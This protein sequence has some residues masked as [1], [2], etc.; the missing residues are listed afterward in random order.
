PTSDTL[1]LEAGNATEGFDRAPHRVTFSAH[2]PYQAHATFA[3]NCALADVKAGSALVMCSSQDVYNTRRVLAPL[4]GLTEQQ[5]RVQFCDGAGTY[6]HSCYDDATQA[7]ALLSQLAGAPVRVQFMRAD[8]HGWDSYGPAHVGEVRAAADAA[9]KIVAYEYHGW[10]HHWSLVETSQ[11]LALG[12]AP[13]EW[14]N[15]VSQQV[16]PSNCGA[17]YVI[18]NKRLVDHRLKTANYLRAGWLRSP[19]DLSMAFAS[20]QAIDDLAFQLGMD[21]YEFRRRNMTDE[22]WLGVLDAAA[23]AAGWAP[24]AGR[25]VQPEGKVVRGRGIGLGTHL[26]SW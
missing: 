12:S 4:L 11:Q 19:L 8:E 15:L 18:P 3:P 24:R 14:P 22:R 10:H 20:E 9:G 26:S 1:V 5:I 25:A 23:K 6:G 7:A 2:C 16:S 21:A 13:D 17:M